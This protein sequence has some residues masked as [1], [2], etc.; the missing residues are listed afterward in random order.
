MWYQ[1]ARVA[2][3]NGEVKKVSLGIEI[4]PNV[5]S[6]LADLSSLGHKSLVVGGAVRDAIL[7]F[8]PKDIDI[9]VYNID[10]ETLN[11]VLS[12]KGRVDLVGKKFGII[13]FTDPGSG[14]IYDFSI[15]RRDNKTGVGHRDFSVSFDRDI[16]PKD[17]AARRDFT[18]NACAYDPISGELHDYFNG[19]DD[20]NSRTLRA[21][22]EHFSEDPLRV[23]RG[24]QF[25]A[26]FGMKLDPE[27]QMM[28]RRMITDYEELRPQMVE[29]YKSGG[30]EEM[31]QAYLE[32]RELRIQELQ[33]ENNLT[34]EQAEKRIPN[35]VNK[36]FPADPEKMFATDIHKSMAVERITE[37]WMKLATK[38]KTPGDA[39]E[40]LTDSGWIQFYPE[41]AA[42]A[43]VPQDPEWHPEGWEYKKVSPISRTQS[44]L[45]VQTS[46]PT[47]YC[48][49]HIEA[50][51]N[52]AH[53]VSPGVRHLLASVNVADSY[54]LSLVTAQT[55]GDYTLLTVAV[56]GPAVAKLRHGGISGT[57]EVKAGDVMTHT[58][59]V[60]N[61]AANIADRE[62]LHGDRRAVLVLSAMCHDLAKPP[63]TALLEKQG[64]FRWTSHGHEPAGGPL[65]KNLLKSMGI[66]EDLV[67]QIVPL[68]ANH[69]KHID[70]VPGRDGV[71]SVRKLAND[72]GKAD[73]NMF[74]LLVEA[75]HS[76]RPPLPA[77]RPHQ[78]DGILE[79]ADKDGVSS[80]L[81]NKRAL[82]GG[83][84]FMDASGMGPGVHIGQA[85]DE[86]YSDWLKGNTQP[87][88]EWTRHYVTKAYPKVTSQMVMNAYPGVPPGPHVGQA[89]KA[90]KDAQYN[91]LVED[92]EEW[93]SQY[94]A[95]N[96]H[97]PV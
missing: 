75:D 18:V 31:M 33:M 67:D 63:T 86:Y 90:A 4:S 62:N 74:S 52:P 40:F 59:H 72:L 28:C 19:L 93:L 16:T 68:V 45:T 12:Q 41:L 85:Q 3:N 91:R 7:G 56:T 53:L 2:N 23:L 73:I 27:T 84:A 43:K 83:Q 88:D 51:G 61:A 24:L 80:G 81:P 6:L 70:F 39:L 71:S 29:H 95:N 65:T 20:L 44:D 17:A 49:K 32:D 36:K 57:V 8:S 94:V 54:D 1:R 38:G 96:P 47:A 25:A 48:A 64:V 60:M 97:K 69:L 66:K 89:M 14:E 46:L 78:L 15:P 92:P 34:L 55:E 76:G 13:K 10:Y 50:G 11:K 21:T 87:V 9:E 30:R 37:E 58:A 77:S 82:L 22:S 35:E 5:I 42:L 26:R 79:L